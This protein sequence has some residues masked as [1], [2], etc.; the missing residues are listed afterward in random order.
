MSKLL[1]KPNIYLSREYCTESEG[2]G[3]TWIGSRSGGNWKILP[4]LAPRA[5]E[6]GG[7]KAPLLEAEP[8]TWVV[9]RGSKPICLALF[10]EIG[11]PNGLPFF[12]HKL[13]AEI[14]IMMHSAV[15]KG[16][17]QISTNTQ[18]RKKSVYC[19][20]ISQQRSDNNNNK[21]GCALGNKRKSRKV[22]HPSIER[23]FWPYSQ[24]YWKAMQYFVLLEY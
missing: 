12:K 8:P 5:G 1:S 21:R 10:L 15:T 3:G 13:N 20:S 11:S 22:I 6:C 23:S 19:S 16:Q 24:I 17:H 7:R 4:E 9:F 14:K 18:K 2:L